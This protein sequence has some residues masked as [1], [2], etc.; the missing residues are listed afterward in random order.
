MP[1]PLGKDCTGG[2]QRCA[3]IQSARC[4]EQYLTAGVALQTIEADKRRM[5]FGDNGVPEANKAGWLVLCTAYQQE[6]SVGNYLLAKQFDVFNPYYVVSGDRSDP[7]SAVRLPLFPGY[8]FVAGAMTRRNQLLTVPGVYTIVSFGR[9]PAEI[10]AAEIEP[11]RRAM[12]CAMRMRPHPFLAT[13][14]HATIAKGPLAG[15]SGFLAPTDD[16]NERPRLVLS[17]QLIGKSVAVEM[18]AGSIRLPA[19]AWNALL[20]LQREEA[21]TN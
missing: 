19:R 21:F 13:G 10:S 20:P 11:I 14:E 1:V 5:R 12:H 18:D 9:V 8:V 7:V 4:H 15:V 2:V 3:D 16:Q 6:S 17:V